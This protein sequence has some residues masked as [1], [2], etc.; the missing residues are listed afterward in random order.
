MIEHVFASILITLGPRLSLALA[1]T[2]LAAAVYLLIWQELSSR[3]P[4]N[5]IDANRLLDAVGLKMLDE[6]NAEGLYDIVD[7]G[8][9][10]KVGQQAVLARVQGR[11]WD[12]A[13]I[14]WISGYRFA[15]GYREG[16][17]Q[18]GTDAG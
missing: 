5:I 3:V 2:V 15:A 1:L 8:T 16:K 9:Q 12:K 6:P 13:I 4:Q 18:G 14:R 10:E 17:R 11:D 7:K